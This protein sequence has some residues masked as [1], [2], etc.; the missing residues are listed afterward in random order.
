MR[1]IAA[2]VLLL[3]AVA[4]RAAV[5]EVTDCANDSHLTTTSA[6]TRLQVGADDLVLHCPL[7]PLPGTD[8]LLVSGHDVTVEGPGSMSAPG[9]AKSSIEATGAVTVQSTSLESSNN[10]GRFDILAAGDILI[11]D[12]HV[13]VGG[14]SSGGD[15]LLIEC[16]STSPACTVTISVSELKSRHLTVNGVG[17]VTVSNSKLVTN[18]PTDFI[19]ITSTMGDVDLGDGGGGNQGDC[20]GM[21]GG[22]GNDIVSGS[23]GNLFILAFGRVDLSGAN[24]LVAEN[25]CGRAGVSDFNNTDACSATCSG[26]VAAGV[27]AD[28]DLT[29]ASIRN[30]IGKNGHIRFC[31]D[32]TRTLLDIDGAVLIQE[33]T[34]QVNAV[35]RLNECEVVPR[36]DPPC[37][38]VVGTPTTDS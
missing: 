33:D 21:G 13:T 22:G 25:I 28:V 17:D 14:P 27:A 34:S 36:T 11:D 35:S 5:V 30:D 18:S 31:A 23:E 20:C 19:R 2:A 12:S 6:E 32:E 38:N 24:V 7:V 37:T 29:N 15:L 8:H 1:T 9:N 4:A 16:T 10:N 26:G 3:A